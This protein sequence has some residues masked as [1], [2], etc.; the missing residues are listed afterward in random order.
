MTSN[1]IKIDPPGT[2]LSQAALVNLISKRSF[3]ATSFVDVG[4]G[5]GSYSKKII[6]KFAIKGTGV[7]S[8]P[9]AI[10]VSK[11][12]LQEEIVSGIYSLI[13][14]SSSELTQES[15]D[16]GISWMVIEHLKDE[17]GF[18]ADC[19]NAIK[20]GGQFY[21]AVPA[22]EELWGI[23]DDTAGHYRRYSRESLKQVMKQAGFKNI[24]VI[25]ANVPISNL[26]LSLSNFLIAR[27]EKSKLDLSM[28]EQT[29]LSGIR[30]IPW[31]T[32]FPKFFKLLLNEV[33]LLPLILLQ[34]AFY[35]TDFGT[36][37]IAVGD[38]D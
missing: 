21:F 38:K 37:I 4:C 16:F 3:G 23:E 17:T 6:S 35:Q 18:I 7:D 22:R 15:F 11:K 8:S 19:F 5:G 13:E 10:A 9:S 1:F 29:A 12:E 20:P 32:V 28:E 26:L 34:K 25:S 27:E 2:I 24:E 31:K 14:G 30:E 33:T 36:V